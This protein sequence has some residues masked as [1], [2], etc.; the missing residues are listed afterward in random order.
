MRLKGFVTFALGAVSGSNPGDEGSYSEIDINENIR[1]SEKLIEGDLKGPRHKSEINYNAKTFSG[2]P[3]LPQPKSALRDLWFRW[4]HSV[5]YVAIPFEM[6]DY[7]PTITRG[8]SQDASTNYKLRTCVDLKPWE[9]EDQYI[10]IFQG[11]GCYSYLGWSY[12]SQ[13]VLSIGSRCNSQVGTFQHEF[14]HA[15]GLFHEQSRPDRDTYVYINLTDVSPGTEGNFNKYDFD[16]VSI[17]DVP[18]DYESVMHYSATGFVQT[19]GGTSIDPYIPYFSKV[20]GQRKDFSRN[21]IA[22]INRMYKCAGPLLNSFFCEFTEMNIGGFVNQPIDDEELAKEENRLDWK[23]YDI[24]RASVVGDTSANKLDDTNGELREDPLVFP[25]SDHSDG[26]AGFGRYMVLNGSAYADVNNAGRNGLLESRQFETRAGSQC[27]E[28]WTNIEGENSFVDVEVWESDNVYGDVVGRFPL[29]TYRVD[30]SLTGR[31]KL[32]NINRW[33]INAPKRF[34]ILIRGTLGS[35]DDII[36]IDDVSLL[37]R[38]CESHRWAIHD[39]E[40]LYAEKKK[41]EYV[42]SPM[43]EASTGHKFVL[44]FYPRGHPNRDNEDYASL[45][46][47]LHSDSNDIEGLQWPWLDQYMKFI[48]QDQVSDVLFRMDQNRIRTTGFQDENPERWGKVTDP[49][50]NGVS[51]ANGTIGYETFLPTF[52]IFESSYSYI[53][54]DTIMIMLDV[55]DLSQLDTTSK[56]SQCTDEDEDPTK[57]SGRCPGMG[58]ACMNVDDTYRCTCHYPFVEQGD[59]SCLCPPGYEF[60]P[61]A[62]EMEAERLT[63]FSLCDFADTNPC[64]EDEVCEQTSSGVT[65]I[66]EDQ[67]TRS[68]TLVQNRAKADVDPEILE[69]FEADD[70]S[71]SEAGGVGFTKF[72]LGISIAVAVLGTMLVVLVCY[73]VMQ[74]KRM[75]RIKRM[76]QMTMQQIQRF[77]PAYKN[78]SF[79]EL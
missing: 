34:K 25:D 11:G 5:N 66:A 60:N 14:M 65:C 68:A 12:Y 47:H 27:L 77:P 53:K 13:Q 59:G 24:K 58:R 16:L 40:Q 17:E 31:S 46:L 52:D 70:V 44:R 37:D 49:D 19:P 35:N 48:A 73:M 61:D 23:Q 76:T 57:E 1:I 29:H 56:L 67:P 32:W 33:T 3:Q 43:M 10:R 30:T 62:E 28:V 22:K 6:E 51:I 15:L 63:C 71:T 20:I 50:E 2:S 64:S 75:Q 9:G 36:A 39:F 7:M 55:R 74:Y 38:P 8:I 42:E 54:H 79:R 4:P 69:N 45:F 26:R 78:E 18:Y 72:E 21:D 41:G